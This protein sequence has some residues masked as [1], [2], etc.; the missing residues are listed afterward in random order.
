MTLTVNLCVPFGLFNGEVGVVE[1]KRPPEVLP[2]LVL[3]DFPW[4]TGPAF[5]EERP[6]LLPIVPVVRLIDCSCH[7]CS[8]KQIPLR[9]GWA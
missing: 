3:V 7:C 2:D 6:T 1:D 8:S 4:Y 9:L 5:I